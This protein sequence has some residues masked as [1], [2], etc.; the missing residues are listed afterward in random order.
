MPWGDFTGNF[1]QTPG[2]GCE[3]CGNPVTDNARARR[4]QGVLLCE[5]CG[6][7]NLRHDSEWE[8]EGSGSHQVGQGTGLPYE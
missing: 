5:I 1:Y 6:R 8:P 2:W 4:Q 3:N 7:L